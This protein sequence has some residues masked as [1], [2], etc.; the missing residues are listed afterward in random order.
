MLRWLPTDDW[1]GR[2]LI[3]GGVVALIGVVVA[4][5]GEVARPHL[6]FRAIAVVCLI[7]AAGAGGSGLAISGAGQEVARRR[8]GTRLVPF[9]RERVVYLW[10][11]MPLPAKVAF[12]IV[13]PV[14][15]TIITFLIVIGSPRQLVE[16]VWVLS[17]ALF[18]V[19]LTLAGRVQTR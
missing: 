3:G 17:L 12:G 15:V 2:L 5:T 11:S 10:R 7:T 9:Y 8:R 6:V 4:L 18:F 1:S 14:A 16:G 19:L 13:V